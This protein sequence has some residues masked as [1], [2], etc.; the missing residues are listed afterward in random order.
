MVVAWRRKEGEEMR[1]IS[2]R[3][4]KLLVV[5]CSLLSSF[6]HRTLRNEYDE[7]NIKNGAEKEREKEKKKDGDYKLIW[8]GFYQSAAILLLD[9]HSARLGLAQRWEE[10]EEEEKKRGLE[11]MDGWMEGYW[12]VTNKRRILCILVG[13]K[14]RKIGMLLLLLLRLVSLMQCCICCQQDCYS[15]SSSSCTRNAMQCLWCIRRSACLPCWW[16]LS[17][18]LVL[19]SLND[20]L[21]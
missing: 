21:S 15:S 19:C 2:G 6:I 10:E 9:I 17:L 4:I 12:V 16:L 7:E 14:P 8:W 13:Q 11:W 18:S 20:R 5:G 1:S 3:V